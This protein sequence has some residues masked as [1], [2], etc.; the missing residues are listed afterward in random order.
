MSEQYSQAEF[1]RDFDNA[2]RVHTVP[3]YPGYDERLRM[4]DRHALVSA[5]GGIVLPYDET[6]PWCPADF[7][8]THATKPQIP[9][10]FLDRGDVYPPTL[11]EARLW[12]EFGI[13]RDQRHMPIHPFAEAILLGG[14]TPEG[15]FVQPGGVVT[16]GY[17]YQRGPRKTGDF[18]L[19]A[20]ENGQLHGLVIERGDNGLLAIP[21][22]HI[23]TEDQ[24]ASQA[25]GGQLN[26]YAIGAIREL[27]E[28]AGVFIDDRDLTC[29][30]LRVVLQKI[31]AGPGA[32]QRATLHAWPQG[33]AFVG[34]LPAM[35]TQQP[36]ASSDAET[37]MWLPLSEATLDRLAKF[38]CHGTIGRRAVAAYEQATGTHVNP[39][40]TIG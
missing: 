20:P 39:D 10:Q 6:Q 30:G 25:M 26:E 37:A 22:G 40:G 18:L 15:T 31:W 11:E 38:S 34:I 12:D 14:E 9:G 7:Y 5:D 35:P 32:D 27:A 8:P 13:R 4:A 36:R 19:V 21:G 16:P 3:G 1:L 33:E 23:E 28:E 24:Q 29:S 2:L 17:Y